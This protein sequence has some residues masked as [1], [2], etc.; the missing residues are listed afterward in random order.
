MPLLLQRVLHWVRFAEHSQRLGVDFDPLPLRGGLFDF[1]FDGDAGS[2]RDVLDRIGIS[3]HAG[4]NHDLQIGEATAV[5]EF[6]ERER[7]FGI[8]PRANPASQIDDL[9]GLAG[10]QCLGNF[11][12]EH[13]STPFDI[14]ETFRIP[15]A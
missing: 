2:G 14:R 10:F 13:G 6:D 12:P 8:S 9:S 3:R 4:I 15:P 5:I 11:H 1:P 7:L